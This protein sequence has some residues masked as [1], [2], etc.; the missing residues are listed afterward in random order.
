MSKANP[1]LALNRPI[2]DINTCPIKPIGWR[3]VIAPYEPKDTT[4]G[5]I[6]I[7][8]QALESERLLT[9]CGRI[10]A[11]GEAAYRAKTRS[12][13]E[14]DLWETRPKVGD[15]VLYGSYGGQRVVMRNG[16]RYLVTNDDA[17][18][19]IVNGP[20]DFKHYL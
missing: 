15:W 1:A 20:E 18:L 5:G 14:M 12:G 13:L 7:A 6:V 11:M 3:I 9:N 4:A 19:A 10:V 8:E 16:T 2:P 17:I